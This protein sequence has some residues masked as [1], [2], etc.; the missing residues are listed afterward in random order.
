MRIFGVGLL[1]ERCAVLHLR[2][3]FLAACA[4]AVP[5][6]MQA[7]ATA[8]FAAT[9]AGLSSRPDTQI[10]LAR[11]AAPNRDVHTAYDRSRDLT[12]IEVEPFDPG[13]GLELRIAA[14]Y[15]GHSPN[16]RPASVRFEFRSTSFGWAYR[17]HNNLALALPDA[18]IL[19]YTTGRAWKVGT[20]AHT[21][22][23]VGP[24]VAEV[25]TFDIPWADVQHLIQAGSA[26]G[27]L[28]ATQIELSPRRVAAIKDFVSR[29]A[30]AR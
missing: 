9:P 28:G 27:M 17:D 4:V 22:P 29:I 12:T 8:A 20:E 15:I 24:I 25:M 11:G 6:A 21:E 18:S 14:S 13:G 16:E 1:T 23:N 19:R 30:P 3:G 26:V 7:Q 5:C 2:F 10:V